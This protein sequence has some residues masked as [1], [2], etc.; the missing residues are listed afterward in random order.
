MTNTLILISF[1]VYT[2]IISLLLHRFFVIR[3]ER[4]K[5][6]K[7]NVSA[8]RWSS[9]TK[10]ILGGITFY[11]IFIFS[12]LNYFAFFNIEALL[13]P[14]ILGMILAVTVAFL[15]GLA[16]DMLNT[17]PGFKFFF[18]I[19][20]GI[21]LIYSDVYIQV[22]ESQTLNYLLTIF[23]VIGIMNSLNMLDNMDA[24]TTSVSST[25]LLGVIF[26]LSFTQPV[27]GVFLMLTLGVLAS[28][29]SFLYYNWNPSKMYM[30][31]NGSQFLGAFVAI[32]GI[33][34]FWNTPAAS[35][36][37]LLYPSMLTFLAFV[38]PIS[39]TTT[40]TINRL[41]RGQ[42]PFVGGRDH[43]TH[44]LSYFGFSD[45]KVALILLTTNLLFVSLSVI[46]I[47]KP[48]WIPI[49]PWYI[50]AVAFIVLVTLYSITKISRPQK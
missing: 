48:G 24:I 33:K 5:I 42:S 14:E 22:F 25:I 41:M 18:Q 7:A 4:Y 16:D 40:V 15:M 9:Q 3:A 46:L 32:V 21:I 35:G 36:H 30:G 50:A 43:T 17:P 8:E 2:L 37:S 38:V 31:D 10:P 11:V 45:R 34:V 44:H 6:K 19:I 39:D 29:L 23:W 27:S 49:S 47:V 1:F 26:I 13:K 28:L 20:C 12:V